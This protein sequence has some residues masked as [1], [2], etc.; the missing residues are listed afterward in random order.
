M[1]IEKGNLKTLYDINSEIPSQEEWITKD[2]FS[3]NSPI[4]EFGK[5]LK[6]K[7]RAMYPGCSLNGKKL[8]PYDYRENVNRYFTLTEEETSDLILKTQTIVNE[9]MHPKELKDCWLQTT[10]QIEGKFNFKWYK[11]LNPPVVNSVDIED[12]VGSDLKFIFKEVVLFMIL[13]RNIF[14]YCL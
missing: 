3:F 8:S 12:N 7:Y 4:T 11:Q 14:G 6:Q 2:A 1:V 10:G 13:F 5:E 9:T